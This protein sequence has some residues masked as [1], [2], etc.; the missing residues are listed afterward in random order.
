M[1]TEP[2][3][4]WKLRNTTA[5]NLAP[6]RISR[7]MRRVGALV[8]AL[9]VWAWAAPEAAGQDVADFEHRCHE[10]VIAVHKT[11]EA[12]FT[13]A[14]PNTDQAFARFSVPMAVDFEIVSPRGTRADRGTILDAVRAAH[15][16]RHASFS[17]TIKNIRTRFLQPPL[18][19]LTYEEWQT[20]SGVTTARLSSVLLRDD[21]RKPGGVAWVHLHET[22]LAGH[23]PSTGHP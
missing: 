11:I 13:G 15:A 19:L 18:A 3:A 20:E 8:A 22:W 2:C 21:P 1:I 10:E 14:L 7:G 12:W 16:T 6:R 23:A 17:I 5:R 9:T 4:T